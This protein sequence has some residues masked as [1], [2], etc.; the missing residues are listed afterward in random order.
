[1]GLSNFFVPLIVRRKMKQ[2][3]LFIGLMG[4]WTLC[5]ISSVFG[6]YFEDTVSSLSLDDE[7]AAPTYQIPNKPN[8]TSDELT[9]K[10]KDPVPILGNLSF[11]MKLRTS[12]VV[13]SFCKGTLISAEVVKALQTAVALDPL[14]V[15][16]SLD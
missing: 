5:P 15:S 16:A 4:L 7:K 12:L 11:E 14:V 1:M 6:S 10:L 9:L 2:R 8:P 3:A 13:G